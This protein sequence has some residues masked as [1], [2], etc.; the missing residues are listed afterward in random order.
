M[1]RRSFVRSLS[2]A[3]A[4]GALGTPEPSR[5]RPA[6]AGRVVALNASPGALNLELDRTAVLVI[7]MQ[8][9]F[10]S[11]GGCFE[12]AGIDISM[13]Q[14]AVAPTARVLGAARRAGL[15][16]VY[17]KMGFK[18]DLS[19]LGPAASPNYQRHVQLLDVGRDVRAPNGT[20]SRFLIRDTWNTDI[21]EALAPMAGE[22]VIYKCR[23]SG[24][25]GTNL[26]DVL[27]RRG[28]RSLVVT[29]CTTS[30]C[31]EATIRDAMFRDYSC[32][33]LKDCTGEPI[34]HG[35]S[36]SNHE[37]SLLSIE[38]LLG[39]ISTSDRLEDALSARSV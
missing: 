8:N 4:V 3:V 32:V 35:L 36:R 39:W 11:V 12:R 29:G 28:V 30:I 15:P 26:H 14:A 19:D 34:G 6:A 38:T 18:P 21:V 13:I 16:V 31:V 17:L 23:F 33:L 1:D 20:A 24:F 25:F 5:P 2:G 7:D 9:D 22:T 37:A 10:G 27:Q